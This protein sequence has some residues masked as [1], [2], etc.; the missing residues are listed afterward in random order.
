MKAPGF[1]DRRKEMLK[2]IAV[3]TG[4]TAFMDG[5]GASSKSV[6]VRDLGQVRRAVLDKE[7]CTTGGRPG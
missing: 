2:D 6:D 3:L 7:T 4:A 1:G 5:L